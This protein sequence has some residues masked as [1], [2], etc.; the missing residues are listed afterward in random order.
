MALRS[1]L[2]YLVASLPALQ[3]GVRSPETRQ[4]SD[5]AENCY[6][7]QVEYLRHV[8]EGLL[9]AQQRGGVSVRVVSQHQTLVGAS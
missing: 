3:L 4:K 5:K 1:L 6:D 2:L 8:Q 7:T 9:P